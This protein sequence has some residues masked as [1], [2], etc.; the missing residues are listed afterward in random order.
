MTRRSTPPFVEIE[1]ADLTAP[2]WYAYQ[3]MFGEAA[4]AVAAGETTDQLGMS[5]GEIQKHQVDAKDL[6]LGM[7]QAQK[8]AL[9]NDGAR[10]LAER[11]AVTLLNDS[12]GDAIVRWHA[13]I[14]R[15]MRTIRPGG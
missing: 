3:Q 2:E 14:I 1:A 5:P 15:R 9:F 12:Q 6:D 4:R 11:G 10:R 8:L 13:K 7:T